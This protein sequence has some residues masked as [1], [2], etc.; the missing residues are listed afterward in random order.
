MKNDN[1]EDISHRRF[2][3]AVGDVH[4]QFRQMVDLLQIAEKKLGG[5]LE[6][7]LQVGDFEP[8]RNETDL[9]SVAAPEKYL[10][11][12]D[13]PDVLS[14]QV[15]FP[16]PVHFIGGNHEPYTLLET[17]PLGG[18]VAPNC[19]YMGRVGVKHI[20]GLQ[21]AGLTGIF[22]QLN[23]DK[24][25]PPLANMLTASKKLWTYFNKGDVQLIEQAA[26][27]PVDVLLL[28]DWP[29]GLVTAANVG[30]LQRH[31]PRIAIDGVGN[32]VGSALVKTLSPQLV[33]CGHMHI[34]HFASLPGKHGR[35]IPVRCLAS[36]Q[37]RMEAIAVFEVD[38]EGK[39]TECLL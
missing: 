21:V 35:E 19:H 2:F 3:A 16:W 39:I 14:G 24:S 9:S 10:H 17:M 20:G 7:V 27:Q 1:R 15:T 5:S 34:A 25:R 8:V 26:K 37:E 32:A 12:G 22:S 36:V 31:N 11:M 23:H 33:L 38:A 29:Q 18:D 28:H 30:A 6:F 13:F 4:G